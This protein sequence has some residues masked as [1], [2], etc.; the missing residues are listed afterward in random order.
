MLKDFEPQTTYHQVQMICNTIKIHFPEFYS[1]FE[2][3]RIVLRIFIEKDKPSSAPYLRIFYKNKN[4]SQ[5]Y[6][7]LVSKIIFRFYLKNNE[8]DYY[9]AIKPMTL[10]KYLTYQS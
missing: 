8:I 2:N 7:D 3:K 5:L 6:I 1:E 9:E 10:S 4:T